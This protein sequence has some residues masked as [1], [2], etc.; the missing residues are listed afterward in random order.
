[1]WMEQR[2]VNG[3]EHRDPLCGGEQPTGPSHGL[4]RGAMKIAVAAVTLPPSNWEEEINAAFVGDARHLETI[5]PGCLPTLRR[6]CSGAR[7]GAVRSKQADFQGILVIHLDAL[8]H[9]PRLDRRGNGDIL[10]G[11]RLA[12]FPFCPIL[13]EGSYLVDDG[14][15]D[16]AACPSDHRGMSEIWLSALR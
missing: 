2:G 4:K 15:R 1:E 10:H 5:R 6:Q 8:G 3:A 11:V 9:R 12:V 13:R 16:G 7:G 14:T